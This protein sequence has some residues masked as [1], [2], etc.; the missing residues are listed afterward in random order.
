MLIE[1][2]KPSSDL[3]TNVYVEINAVREKYIKSLKQSNHRIRAKENILQLA[4]KPKEYR[5]WE[6][7]LLYRIHA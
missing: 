3:M 4:F 5:M 2:S 6:I 7:L 1:H